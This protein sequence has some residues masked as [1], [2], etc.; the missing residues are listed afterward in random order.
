MKVKDLTFIAM[1]AAL[2]AICSWISIPTTIPFTLQTLG[3]FLA[4]GLLGRGRGTLS[5]I[6]FLLLG[7]IGLPVFSG[8]TGGIGILMGP[9]GGYLIGFIF[10]ALVMGTIT[11]RFGE[12]TV[13]LILAMIAGLLVCYLFGTAWFMLVYNHTNEAISLYAT[14]S[15]CVFPFIVPDLLKICL[16]VLLVRRLKP[17]INRY[18]AA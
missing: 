14:L 2:M 4:V 11:T 1:F 15:A 12:S 10:T 5:V 9:T 8:F 18:L 6:T 17:V 3:V 7:L 16:S 13:V